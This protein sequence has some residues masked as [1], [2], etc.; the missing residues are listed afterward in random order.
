MKFQVSSVKGLDCSPSG[1]NPFSFFSSIFYIKRKR[2]RAAGATV[3]TLDTSDLK[4]HTGIRKC[5]VYHI[6]KFQVSSVRSRFLMNFLLKKWPNGYLDVR[7]LSAVIYE[8][9]TFLV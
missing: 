2:F 6:L 7:R 1:V 8:L 9:D 5:G 4:F 3:Q